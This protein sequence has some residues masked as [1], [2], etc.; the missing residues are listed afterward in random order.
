MAGAIVNRV[1]DFL[2]METEEEEYDEL[3]NEGYDYEEVEEEEVEA[4]GLFGRRNKVVN[5]ESG[6]WFENQTRCRFT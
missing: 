4:R 6:V 1:L 3:E 5:R 2:G